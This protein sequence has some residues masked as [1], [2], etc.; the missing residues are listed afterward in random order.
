ETL[1]DG[2]FQPGIDCAGPPEG[3]LALYKNRFRILRSDSV[4]GAIGGAD[5]NYKGFM[6]ALEPSNVVEAL[7][8]RVSAVVRRH[9]D[10]DRL[11]SHVE[12][13]LATECDRVTYCTSRLHRAGNG[14]D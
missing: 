14:R 12:L 8:Q 1:P 7:Q 13:L 6:R 5:Y 11:I 4:A 9:D 10:G 3:L 2:F